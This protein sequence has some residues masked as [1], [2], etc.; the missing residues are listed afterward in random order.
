MTR[1]SCVASCQRTVIFI[2]VARLV[3]T[4]P[5]ARRPSFLKSRKAMWLFPVVRVNLSHYFPL[6]S[7]HEVSSQFTTTWRHPTTCPTVKAV[8]KIVLGRASMA[9][10]NTYRWNVSLIQSDYYWVNIKSGMLSKLA[11]IGLAEVNLREMRTVGGMAPPVLVF[12]ETMATQ[13]SARQL[14]AP[15]ATS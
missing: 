14:L 9:A 2:S 5:W 13:P 4:T 11:V 1:V 12:L 7:V 10:Y 3:E 15:C 8:Y 6:N